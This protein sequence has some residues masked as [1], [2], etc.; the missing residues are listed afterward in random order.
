MLNN[1]NY[2]LELN[3]YGFQFES[4]FLLESEIMNQKGAAFLAYHTL[5]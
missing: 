5:S 3:Y 1:F 2:L 4:P